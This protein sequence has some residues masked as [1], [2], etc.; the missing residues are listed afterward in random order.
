MKHD[1]CRKGKRV[2]GFGVES[3]AGNRGRRESSYNRESGGRR[4][5]SGRRES[6][7]GLSVNTGVKT[8]VITGVKTGVN[9]GAEPSFRSD[10]KDLIKSGIRRSLTPSE[11]GKSVNREIVMNKK[12]EI[13]VR[14]KPNGNMN[15]NNN[16]IGTQRSKSDLNRKIFKKEHRLSNLVTSTVIKSTVMCAKNSDIQTTPSES[17]NT[18]ISQN[19]TSLDPSSLDP[20][21]LDPS[22]LDPSLT[23]YPLT[24]Y[25][26]NSFGTSRL[27]LPQR[28][29]RGLVQPSTGLPFARAVTDLSVISK[30]E[31]LKNPKNLKNSKNSTNSS[32]NSSIQK[33]NLLS[34]RQKY[35]S[36][37]SQ[38]LNSLNRHKP[39]QDWKQYKSQS[40]IPRPDFEKNGIGLQKILLSELQSK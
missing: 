7:V 36:L 22:S 35:S 2:S 39:R 19:S 13:S 26:E 23:N 38:S 18:Q 20:S 10:S 11:N 40:K 24:N 5:S 3:D 14:S 8:G 34:N 37:S 6:G 28:K 27:T 1:P 21:S 33:F 32:E 31:N 17:N 16:L 9:P 4:E 15:N 29:P 25:H 30:L 12:Q